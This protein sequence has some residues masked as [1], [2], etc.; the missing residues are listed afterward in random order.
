MM[1]P[2]LTKKE[3]KLIEQCGRE[4]EAASFELWKERFKD[5]LHPSWSEKTLR[6]LYEAW[7][8]SE[9]D[10]QNLGL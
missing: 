9:I 4:Y 1:K 5:E 8:K 7:N 10:K 3:A 6:K 2:K